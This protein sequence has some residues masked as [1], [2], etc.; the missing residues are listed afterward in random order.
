LTESERVFLEWMARQNVET[1]EAFQALLGEMWKAG[2]A[3]ANACHEAIATGC[4]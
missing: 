3:D 2:Q 4:A 1:G